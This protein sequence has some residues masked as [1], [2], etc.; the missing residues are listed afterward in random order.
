M[1]FS[2]K[3]IEQASNRAKGKCECQKLNHKHPTGKCG[4]ELVFTNRNREGRGRWEARPISKTFGDTIY[5]C[6]ILCADCYK[7]TLYER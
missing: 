3:V 4:K 2:E 1:V 5:N 6:E 7:L